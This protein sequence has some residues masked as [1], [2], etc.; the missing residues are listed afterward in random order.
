M[1]RHLIS[2]PHW[3]R[4]A[5]ILRRRP[6]QSV[7]SDRDQ[8]QRFIDEIEA[9]HPGLARAHTK[10]ELV[11]GVEVIDRWLQV[12]ILRAVQ[13]RMSSAGY[14]VLLLGGL[15]APFLAVHRDLS[16][17]AVRTIPPDVEILF[18]SQL[19][20]EECQAI[21]TAMDDGVSASL[22]IVRE[23][24]KNAPMAGD[25]FA[26]RVW[27][28]CRGCDAGATRGRE[29]EQRVGEYVD[30][31]RGKSRLQQLE[32]ALALTERVLTGT[33]DKPYDRQVQAAAA[34]QMWRELGPLELAQ[35]D[36]V[37]A[38]KGGWL[39]VANLVIRED[40]DRREFVELAKH[41]MALI[42]QDDPV[43]VKVATGST[44]RVYRFHA[45]RRTLIDRLGGRRGRVH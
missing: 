28:A 11:A 29:F 32:M 24:A 6:E 2:A 45:G 26:R 1:P 38:I 44:V 16:P 36:P 14:A 25:I 10:P 4:L 41:S 9:R 12:V 8:D 13:I 5:A 31:F 23:V 27:D 7:G 34:D 15:E 33:R 35:F 22:S 20:E 39:R 17:L 42:C 3:T 21:E 43:D 18:A 37:A 40:S 30:L 19:S